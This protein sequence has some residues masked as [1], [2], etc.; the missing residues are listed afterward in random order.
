M[1]KPPIY[2]SIGHRGEI[3]GFN[4]TIACLLEKDMSIVVLANRT[5]LDDMTVG[6]VSEDVIAALDPEVPVKLTAKSLATSSINTA[7]VPYRSLP[8]AEH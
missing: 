4:A 1:F 5:A 6:P 7:I 2:S 3:V 8:L